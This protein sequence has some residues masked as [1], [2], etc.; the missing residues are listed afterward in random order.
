MK[1]DSKDRLASLLIAIAFLFTFANTT[2][3]TKHT[4]YPKLNRRLG[5]NLKFQSN[6][7]YDSRTGN[8][9]S[10]LI[11]KQIESTKYDPDIAITTET[12]PDGA[13][14]TGNADADFE[15]DKLL[16]Q[17]DN[18]YRNRKSTVRTKAHL[19]SIQLFFNLFNFN[20]FSEDPNSF[21]GE[22]KNY[23]SIV[24]KRG[25]LFYYLSR[26][27]LYG[28]VIYMF[29]RYV[30]LSYTEKAKP[31][32]Q[33]PNLNRNYKIVSWVQSSAIGGL[34]IVGVSLFL[35]SGEPRLKITDVASDLLYSFRKISH[36]V[37]NII[38]Q[39]KALNSLGLTVPPSNKERFTVQDRLSQAK[40]GVTMDVRSAEDFANALR[41][42]DQLT[43][44]GTPISLLFISLMLSGISAISI[45]SKSPN[46]QIVLFIG[47]SLTLSYILFTVGLFFASYSGI[48]DVCKA[49]VS[50][51]TLDVWPA[52]GGGIA[53]FLGCSEQD[54]FFQQ[55]YAN[56]V[57]QHSALK[58]FNNE[59]FRAKL[60]P[61]PDTS[62][63]SRLSTFLNR[64]DASNTKVKAISNVMERNENVLK[65]LMEINNCNSVRAWTYKAEEDLCYTT[66]RRLM[67]LFAIYWI[68]VVM[69]IIAIV[70]THFGQSIMNNLI[71][72]DKVAKHT[73]NRDR[74]SNDFKLE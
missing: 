72:K 38:Q 31:Y 2:R 28:A 14:T 42:D 13:Y 33:D 48:Y 30:W 55:L 46:M 17:Y 5:E 57:A 24:N 53:H 11:D 41:G 70:T 68:A 58:M 16:P 60:P 15:F 39:N 32:K 64:L 26:F 51:E 69:I 73:F 44:Y 34:L 66:S 62:S 25:L 40:E 50:F 22:Y 3:Q 1:Q 6:E 37:D 21:Q 12:G 20:L 74:F 8:M 54:A 35:L 27:I 47:L 59:M 52:R 19:D 49:M 9:R 71:I 56:M 29:T 61:V 10:F 18:P 45:Y 7:F 65:E 63:A 36:R 23:F 4:S 67:L 43:S